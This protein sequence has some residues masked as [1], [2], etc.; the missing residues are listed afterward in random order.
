MNHVTPFA[1]IFGIGHSV[2][3]FVYHL[4]AILCI[5]HWWNGLNKLDRM[6]EW[7]VVGGREGR[8]DWG[9]VKARKCVRACEWCARYVCISAVPMQY[10]I[11]C[12]NHNHFYCF[13]N[14]NLFP[15]I[16]GYFSVKNIKLEI[17]LEQFRTTTSVVCYWKRRIYIYTFI[18]FNKFRSH[19]SCNTYVWRAWIKHLLIWRLTK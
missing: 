5:W 8:G 13:F 4:D 7:W 2:A 1:Y 18:H 9:A 14:N 15:S 3:M 17:N 11:R 6:K 19:V 10:Y 12:A 16:N